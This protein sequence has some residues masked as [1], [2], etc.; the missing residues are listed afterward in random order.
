MHLPTS[1]SPA[2]ALDLVSTT[3]GVS[4]WWSPEGTVEGGALQPGWMPIAVTRSEEGVRWEGEGLTLRFG[5][6]AGGLG[7]EGEPEDDD[8]RSAWGLQL[9]ALRRALAGLAATPWTQH[10]A[11]AA[12][13]YGDAWGRLGRLGETAVGR[14][15]QVRLGG[16]EVSTV[17]TYVERGRALALTVG[18]ASVRLWFGPGPR[19]NA[20][21]LDVQGEADA[22][23]WV[24]WIDERMAMSWL[25]QTGPV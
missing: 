2:A 8:L 22:A 20:A 18:Q 17:V 4:R 13:S 3:A 15:A 6:V 25:K 7:V 23:A 16:G 12:L 5:A 9:V 21:Y 11:D 10:L 1:L 19:V 14:G 24:R